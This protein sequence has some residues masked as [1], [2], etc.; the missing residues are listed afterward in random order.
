MD[1]SEPASPGLMESLRNFGDGFIGSIH[2][3]VELLS[4]ELHEE[5]FRLIATFIWISA[6]VFCGLLAITFASLTI[7][8]LFW[9]SARL[10]VLG[11]FTAL[12]GIG[13]FVIVRSFRS[14]LKRQPRPFA[15]T[16]AELKHD[17]ECIRPEN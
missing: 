10:A 9:D 3:R 11:G 12:Y 14:F 2:D 13:L 17:R 15:A 7:V 6:A 5:K 8:Y 1:S 16:I 4:V